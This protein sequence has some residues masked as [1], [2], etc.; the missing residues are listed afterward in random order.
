LDFRP[1]EVPIEFLEGYVNAFRIHSLDVRQDG[2][3]PYVYATRVDASRVQLCLNELDPALGGV[4]FCLTLS[5][6]YSLL[7]GKPLSLKLPFLACNLTPTDRELRLDL[8]MEGAIGHR[9]Y[10]L[11]LGEL[12][13]AWN[14]MNAAYLY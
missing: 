8:E 2:C 7:E 1:G 11:A 12:A 3:I 10:P 9:A 14:L 4:S 6:L 13:L 5:H